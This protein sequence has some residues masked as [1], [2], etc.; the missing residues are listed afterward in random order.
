MVAIADPTAYIALHSQIE[1]DAKQRCFTNYLPGFNIP[2]LPRELSDELCSLK[3]HETR[4]ALV[5]YIETDLQGNISAPAKFVLADVQSKDKLTYNH[6][7][8]YLE[9]KDH[10]WQ[11]EN[12]ET[13]QQIHWLHQFTLTRTQWRK[14]HALLFKE[15]PDYSFVLAENG[16]VQEIKAE[17][18]RIANQIVEES[19]IIANICA[20][21]FLHENLQCGIFNTHSGFDKKFLENAHNFLLA[22]LA[23]DENKAELQSRYAPE[24][25][26]T[27]KGYCQMRHDIEPIEGNYLEFRLRRFLTFAEF[28]AELAPH[29]GLGLNG[30]ATW[31]SPIR[32]YSDMVNHRLIKA[33]LAG[34]DFA[35]PEESVLARLQEARRQNRLV[36]RDIA[37][38]LYCRYLADKVAEKPEF[39]AEVQDVSRGGLR[40]LL[41]ENG[42]S[43]FIPAST[44]HDNKEEVVINPDEIAFYVK[45]QCQYKIGDILRVQLTEVREDTR[46]I[47]GV[48]V[49]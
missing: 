1:K 12:P 6:V 46:S 8:D 40:V 13:A 24:N 16:K 35:K 27:L 21:Q 41:L 30:Y 19:M 14:T 32:K 9:G 22:N 44:L 36:E 38:W 5:C 7:S 11:P 20:A 42:A 23:N 47:V 18:R 43:M 4:P 34:R 17:Y 49:K 45:D 29:F 39:D 15:K 28:K 33:H 48:V 37:D 3:P 2:M 26:A 10:A 31:T 25:L